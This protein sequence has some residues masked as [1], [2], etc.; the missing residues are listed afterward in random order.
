MVDA[1][2]VMFYRWPANVA[3]CDLVSLTNGRRAATEQHTCSEWPVTVNGLRRRAERLRR[4]LDGAEDGLADR[5]EARVRAFLRDTEVIT[6][7]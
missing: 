1:G 5:I 3:G 7:S 6:E 2:R 4:R